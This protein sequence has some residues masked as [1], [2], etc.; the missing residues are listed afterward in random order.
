MGGLGSTVL[1]LELGFENVETLAIAGSLSLLPAL[2]LRCELSGV[3]TITAC[4]QAS[5]ARE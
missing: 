1:L 4:S 3:P 5:P 2:D